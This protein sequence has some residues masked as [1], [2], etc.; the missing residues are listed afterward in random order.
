MGHTRDEFVMYTDDEDVYLNMYLMYD[1]ANLSSQLVEG[2][3][4]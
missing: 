4:R 1:G 2:K 3:G